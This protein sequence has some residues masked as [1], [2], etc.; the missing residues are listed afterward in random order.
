MSTPPDTSPAAISAL[1]EAVFN[2]LSRQFPVC[3]GSDEFHFFPQVRATAEYDSGWDDF[4]PEA[5]QALLSEMAVWLRRTEDL[6]AQLLSR[7][8]SVDIETLEDVLQ[9][10]REQLTDVGWHRHQPTWYLTIMGIGLAEA[11]EETSGR[12]ATR[13][14]TLPRFL[15][16]ARDNLKQMPCLF[17]DLGCDMIQGLLPWL[18]TLPADPRL[19]A[20][21]S[22]AIAAFRHTLESAP[23]T[24]DCLPDRDLY[25]R[26]ARHHM[27]CRQATADIARELEDEIQE[28]R[29]LLETLSRDIA[30]GNTWQN[31]IAALPPVALPPAG[32]GALYQAAIADLADHCA[33]QGL[34]TPAF[35]QRCPVTVTPIPAYMLPVRSN[36]AYSMPAGYPPKGGTFYI[37]D[38]RASTTVPAD[39]RLLTA[40][41][42]FPGHHLLDS[43]RWEQTRPVRRHVE[44]PLFY[45]GWASFSEE[46]LFDTGYFHSLTDHLL[47]AKR[48]FW[49]AMRGRV[50]LEIH[51]R[52][53][54]MDQ[55][56]D[57]LVECG[58]PARQAA[59]M[60]KRYALKPGYQLAY[61]M[62]RRQFR[63]L[64]DRYGKSP[65]APAA[66]A[67]RILAQGETELHHLEAN[68]RWSGLP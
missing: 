3:M 16:Q 23:T 48:R 15:D 20:S 14:K 6:K 12:L 26:I 4:S 33:A 34:T 13:L 5:L 50:D 54:S 31:A 51:T 29:S 18:P 65:E 55:A 25:E 68:L 42:T 28:T 57:L 52:R 1:A 24:Q 47:M 44:L 2:R 59:A 8:D 41:E 53:R 46:L 22:E 37:M 35:L 56:A 45:E 21:A 62:G 39:Y 9:T 30:P 63:R 49:R 11:A 66:F 38:T 10:L 36:A 19:R 67:R 61:T 58:L 60:V 27:G 64:Y 17:R 7:E 43:R 32:V 40:H